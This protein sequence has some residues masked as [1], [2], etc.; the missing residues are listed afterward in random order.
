[1]EEWKGGRVE[2]WRCGKVEE[3]KGRR[4]EEWKSGKKEEWKE[5]RLECRIATP[6]G[7][8]KPINWIK[9]ERWKN[10]KIGNIGLLGP[11]GLVSRL[12]VSCKNG[13]MEIG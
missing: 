3:W 11:E 12:I 13:K 7:I 10:G 8:G 5:G 4:V 2:R 1:V 6:K 9:M